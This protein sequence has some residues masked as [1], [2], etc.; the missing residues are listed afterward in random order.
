VVNF[1]ARGIGARTVEQLQ[2]A[3]KDAGKSHVSYATAQGG[4]KAAA[5]AA[6]VAHAEG[7]LRT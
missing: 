3:A 4:G 2:D 7:R 5:F 6:L 1:P